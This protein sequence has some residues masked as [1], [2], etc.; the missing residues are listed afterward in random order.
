MLNY[1]LCVSRFAHYLKWIARDQIGV[2]NTP[3]ELQNLLMKWIIDYVSPDASASAS[4][5][6]KKPL[7]DAEIKVIAIPG[8]AGEYQSIF[9]LVPHHELDDMRVS[10]R[11]DTKLL[12]RR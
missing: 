9:H 4:T 2:C 7:L 3:E 1:M 8:R 11:L 10:I 6:L 12:P 5:R